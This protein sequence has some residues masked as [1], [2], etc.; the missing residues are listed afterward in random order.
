MNKKGLIIFIILVLVVG[1]GAYYLG[2]RQGKAA[3]E[4]AY[5]EIIEKSAIP[6]VNPVEN[7]PTTNPF[8]EVKVNPFEGIYKNPFK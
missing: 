6:G 2:F 4:K 8:K 7:L 3:T 5:K 1:A